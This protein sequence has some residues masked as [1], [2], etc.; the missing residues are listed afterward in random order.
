VIDVN[1]LNILGLVAACVLSIWVVD[2][3]TARCAAR[4]LARFAATRGVRY[5][6]LDRFNLAPRVRA[7]LPHA[8]AADVIVT[9]VMYRTD[10]DR[11]AYVF[12]ATYLTGTT[13]GQSRHRVIAAVT[14]PR[15]RSCD[16]F[17][18]LYLADASADVQTQYASL[19][20]RS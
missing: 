4:R 2:R 12:T 17:G 13:S 7:C 16:C 5:S 18:D 20:D 3:W 19:L 1:A 11:H 14:E 9:D 8:G 10:E 15:G 6:Q